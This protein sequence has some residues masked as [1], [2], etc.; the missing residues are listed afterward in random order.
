MIGEDIPFTL[1]S[2][3]AE[4]PEEELRR[5]LVH[6]QAAEFLYE[7]SDHFRILNTLSNMV[8]L[9]SGLRESRPRSSSLDACCGR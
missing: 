5:H 2:A 9:P 7:A 1:L 8:Y 4:L 3:I 6:L